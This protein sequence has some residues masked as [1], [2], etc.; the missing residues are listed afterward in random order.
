VNELRR[1]LEELAGR[2]NTRGATRV[3][4]DA[5]TKTQPGWGWRQQPAVAFLAVLLVTALLGSGLANLGSSGSGGANATLIASSRLDS[6]ANCDGLLAHLKKEALDRVGPYGLSGGS[7]IGIGIDERAATTSD[8]LSSTP[9]P[10]AALKEGDASSGAA[11]SPDFSSTNVQE[12]DVDEPDVIK[13]DGDTVFA[14]ANGRLWAVDERG[15]PKLLG[16]IAM[17][18]GFQL[19]L[20]GSRLLVLG[21][22]PGDVE[23]MPLVGRA[24]AA[25]QSD[26]ASSSLAPFRTTTTITTVD[27]HDPAAMKVTSSYDVDGQ[28][29]SARLVDGVARIVVR[30]SGPDLPFVYPSSGT[31]ASVRRATESNREVI[32]SSTIADWMPSYRLADGSDTQ[33]AYDCARTYAPPEFS[34]FGLVSVL[35]IDPAQPRLGDSTTVIA[36]GETVYASTDHLYV[37]TNRWE[38]TPDQGTI[39]AQPAD[40]LAA[41]SSA[42]DGLL[43][44]LVH[45]F[46][47]RGSGPARY[48]VSGTVRGT[49]LNQF[50]MSEHNGDLRVATTDAVTNGS[51]SESFV[52]VM[53]DDGKLLTQVGQVGGLGLGEQ[54]KGVR[55]VGDR[56][57]VVTFRQTDPLYVLDLADPAAPTVTG[58]LK[59]PGYSAYLHPLDGD[60]LIGVGPDATEQG[61]VTGTQ[62]SLFDVSDPANPRRLQQRVIAQSSSQAA[63]DHHAF[64]YWPATGL[65]VVPIQEYA[66]RGGSQSYAIGLRLRPDGI[67]TVGQVQHPGA[68][69]PIQRSLVI[70]D[71]LVTFSTSGLLSS[72]LATLSP[73]VWVPLG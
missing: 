43:H 18:T 25:P 54:I 48:L 16:S 17:E 53:T 44:T 21:S 70:G 60:L 37:A 30:S 61:R 50:A 29:I 52:T 46:D 56:G 14:L 15:A 9:Q 72:D 68:A 22:G 6:F 33:P 23:P 39:P 35:T 42:T 36:D 24:P 69:E 34:G 28:Y 40:G 49:V 64:L 38:P 4:T 63:F 41:P 45:E 51:R 58:E 20:A 67:D 47:I 57:Y 3:W 10:S 2:G 73:G 55:F 19:L 8:D 71:R 5:T 27:V 31:D 13:T 65:T 12:A 26:I 59:I 1:R 7:R 62:I 11:S 32:A 66:N